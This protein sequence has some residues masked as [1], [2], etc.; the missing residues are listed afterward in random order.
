M[1]WV[2]VVGLLASIL[3]M[4]GILLYELQ[5]PSSLPALASPAFFLDDRGRVQSVY[6]IVA[7]EAQRWQGDAQLYSAGIV[8]DDVGSEGVL[9]RDLWTFEFFSPSQGQMAVIRVTDGQVERLRTTRLPT[10]LH[11]LPLQQWRIDSTQ[12]LQT[13]WENG[14]G[15]FVRKHNRVSIGLKLRAGPKR[16]R[17]LWTVAGSATEQHWVVRIDSVD[18][19]VVE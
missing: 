6:P 1:Q 11:A 5:V 14:G 2:V 10:R 16:A 7:Q 15:D 18:G 8:W 19:T 3:A 17:T 4:F 12:A 9:K 13:W